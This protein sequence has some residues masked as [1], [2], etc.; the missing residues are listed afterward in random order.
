VRSRKSIPL[1]VQLRAAGLMPR[2]TFEHRFAAPRRWKFDLAFI[3]AKLAVEIDGGAFIA[4]RHVRGAGYR[5][6]IEKF[7]EATCRGWRIL[8][9]LPEQ[10]RSG[11][12]LT[13]IERALKSD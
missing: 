1:D 6:D 4:G 3:D 9:V 11:Q 2:A 13:W 12:A 5:D 10:I 8:R 7:A